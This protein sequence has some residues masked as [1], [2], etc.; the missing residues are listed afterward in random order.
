MNRYHINTKILTALNPCPD[1]LDNWVKHYNNFNGSIFRFLKLKK[2]TA[3]DKIWVF[4][5]LTSRENKEY[6]AIDCAFSAINHVN[7][8]AASADAAAAYAAAYA[9]SIYAAT[10]ADAAYA[11]DAAAA[12]Y[13]AAYADAA[14]DATYADAAYDAERSRQIEA[15]IYL[16]R[17][18][19]D[20]D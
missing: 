12:A 11:A 1:R 20:S 17:T 5:K 7:N 8:A 19:Y 18:K 4:L 9:A 6:F 3:K 15:I 14:Y 16:L 2:I 10:A 13:A